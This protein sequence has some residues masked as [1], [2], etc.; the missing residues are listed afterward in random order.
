MTLMIDLPPAVEARL[1]SEA[2]REGLSIEEYALRKLGTPK[3]NAPTAQVDS[4]SY[5]L[6]LVQ[7]FK[8]SVSEEEWN[9][10]PAD[11]AV[12]YKD[13]IQAQRRNPA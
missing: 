8:D 9:G 11:F 7:E 2:E 5:V 6:K 10:L 13:Y 3:D 1:L 4:G 12:N